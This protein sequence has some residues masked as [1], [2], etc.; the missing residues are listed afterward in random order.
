MISDEMLFRLLMRTDACLRRQRVPEASEEALR[1]PGFGSVLDAL[2][3]LGPSSQRQLVVL[4]RL[5]QPT[6]SESLRLMAEEGLVSRR[7]DESDAR[8]TVLELTEKGR[9]L[10]RQLK[11]QRKKLAQRVFSGISEEEKQM[12]YT[13]LRK[14]EYTITEGDEQ[15]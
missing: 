15:E 6:V 4:T 12:L 14:M 10:Q 11:L 5:R 2:E 13:I 9:E 3:K 7:T 1:H 8:S